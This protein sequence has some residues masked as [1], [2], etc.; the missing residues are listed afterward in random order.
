MNTS[1][2]WSVQRQERG[3]VVDVPDEY[4]ADIGITGLI[5]TQHGLPALWFDFKDRAWSFLTREVIQAFKP[6]RA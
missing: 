3:Y 4:H 5:A 1:A 6:M 2:S